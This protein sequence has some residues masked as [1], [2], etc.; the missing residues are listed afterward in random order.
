MLERMTPLMT[1]EDRL[2]AVTRRCREAGM[3]VTP[4]RLLIYRALLESK[5]HPSPEEVFGRVRGALPNLS[6]ATIYKTLDALVQLGVAT[7]I[8]TL[9]QRRRYDANLEDHHHLICDICGAVVDFY[10]PV[11]D[12]VRPSRPLMG[13]EARSFALHVRGTCGTCSAAGRDADS[14]TS[15]HAPVERSVQT[16]RRS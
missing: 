12:A 11:L 5:D 8:P 3:K 10:D 4:Q 13:F 15:C 9:G 14:K 7:E 1:M 16:K 6:L 2:H